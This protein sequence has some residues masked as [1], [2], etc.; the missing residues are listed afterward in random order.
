MKPRLRGFFRL[1]S[2]KQ[3]ENDSVD[4]KKRERKDCGR[5]EP[6]RADRVEIFDFPNKGDNQRTDATAEDADQKRSDQTARLLARQ[7]TT[8]RQTDHRRETDPDQNQIHPLLG[9][10]GKIVV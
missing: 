9:R 2:Q 3:N 10:Y 7:K 8:N 1:F 5:A 4:Q 6:D